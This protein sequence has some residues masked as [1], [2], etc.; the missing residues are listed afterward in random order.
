MPAAPA[1][2]A[3]KWPDVPG[4]RRLPVLSTLLPISPARSLQVRAL[5]PRLCRAPFAAGLS[6]GRPGSAYAWPGQTHLANETTL[7]NS[8]RVKVASL[9]KPSLPPSPRARLPSSVP[10]VGGHAHMSSTPPRDVPEPPTAPFYHPCPAA[11]RLRNPGRGGLRRARYRPHKPIQEHLRGASRQQPRFSLSDSSVF[12]NL[13]A[14]PT[15]EAPAGVGLCVRGC[16]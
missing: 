10:G 6:P 13:P 16:R 2:G 15:G 4:D 3:G 7:I 11:L 5:P 14:R 9:P 1:R 12:S 8:G